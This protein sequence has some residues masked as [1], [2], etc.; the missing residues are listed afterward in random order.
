METLKSLVYQQIFLSENYL[1]NQQNNQGDFDK[2]CMINIACTS[3]SE[4]ENFSK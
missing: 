3:G 4:H 2:Y 1:V